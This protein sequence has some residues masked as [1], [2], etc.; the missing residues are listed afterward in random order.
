MKAI[1][2]EDY[3]SAKTAAQT[4]ASLT[5][6]LS[7]WLPELRLEAVRVD[8]LLKKSVGDYSAAHA[9]FAK[10]VC[11]SKNLEG[12]ASAVLTSK[13]DLA[14]TFLA[15]SAFSSALPHALAVEHASTVLR[16]DSLRAAATVC[17]VECLVGLDAG[18]I[19]GGGFALLAVEA[20]DAH[21][22][23]VLGKGKGLTH[24]TH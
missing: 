14:E 19:L 17:I 1:A 10:V 2:R 20:M 18:S 23:G 22:R 4:I 7:V 21:A 16:L 3:A 6:S 13:L 9:S 8:G 24:P 5:P 15:A 12:G 11:A